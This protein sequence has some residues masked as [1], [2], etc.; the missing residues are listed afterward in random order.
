[1]RDLYF[2]QFWYLLLIR[3]HL[4]LLERAGLALD[5]TA[6]WLLVL[7]NKLAEHSLHCKTELLWTNCVLYMYQEEG[8]CSPANVQMQYRTHECNVPKDE[9]RKRL[10]CYA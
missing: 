6:T 10:C 7:T 3:Q 5:L 8:Q 2:M 9:E 4:M 1:M